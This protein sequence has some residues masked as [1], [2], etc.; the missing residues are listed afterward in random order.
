MSPK[1]GICIPNNFYNGF[2]DPS[3]PFKFQQ[4]EIQSQLVELELID[5]LKGNNNEKEIRK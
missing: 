3:N 1:D 2:K 5:L 4:A